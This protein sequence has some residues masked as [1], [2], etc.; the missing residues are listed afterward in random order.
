MA[1]KKRGVKEGAGRPKFQ[2]QKAMGNFQS[3]R[4]ASFQIHGPRLFNSLPI[5]VRS[6]TKVGIDDYKVK[7]IPDEPCQ[8]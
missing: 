6:L 1:K 3:M 8:E 4:E 7:S 2:S 5:A